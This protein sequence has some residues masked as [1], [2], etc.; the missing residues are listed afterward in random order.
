MYFYTGSEW[1]NGGTG[2]TSGQAANIITNNGKTSDINHV[3]ISSTA[4]LVEDT[5]LYYTETRVSANTDVSRNK[6]NIAS[7]TARVNDQAALIIGLHAQ[8]AELI[9][10]NT[11]VSRSVAIGTQKWMKKNLDVAT[12]TDGTT[13]PEV[14]DQRVWAELKTGAWCYY[15]NDSANETT[16]GK[17]YNWYAVM[18]ITVAEDAT[19]TAAQ[20]AARKQLAPTGWHVPSH[21]EWT[22]ST[23]FLG[24]NA[25]S[26]GGKM[27][28]TGTA[29]WRSPNTAATNS[30]GFTG[31][32]GGY[33]NTNGTFNYI[34]Y[35]GNW[36]SSTEF[37]TLNA[38]YRY[39]SYNNGDVFRNGYNKTFG[40]S[41]RCLRD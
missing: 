24:G 8:I 27:K 34:G 6:T 9:S 13:I 18:G 28:E 11:L 33:R 14:A 36:W 32:P 2:I 4:D 15:N 7:E 23:A 21:E 31:L 19:P 1:S 29:H 3:L 37:N 5:N 22:T 16:Y 25:D 30:S 40:F 10:D 17:L 41:V 26:A 39:L 38:W 35:Y 20:I 12:Y